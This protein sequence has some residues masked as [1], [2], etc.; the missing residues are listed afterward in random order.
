M[1]A[2]VTMTGLKEFARGVEQLPRAVTLALR[3]VAH[4][5]AGRVYSSAKARLQ[6]QTHGEGKFITGLRIV[7]RDQMKAFIVDVGHVVGR[8]DNLALWLELG[9]VKMSAR[10]FLRP[11]MEE[12]SASYIHEADA[13]VQ[14]AG[15]EA[16]S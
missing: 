15:E 7:E 10:P 12:H 9:T 3:S 6:S 16:L 11:S 5:T 2:G 1:A 4:R 8:P 13:A 14:T